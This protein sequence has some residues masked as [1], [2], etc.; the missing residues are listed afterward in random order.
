MGETSKMVGVPTMKGIGSSFKDFGLGAVGGLLFLI[1]YQIFGAIGVLA[2][3]LIAGSMIKGERGQIISTMAGF[4]VIALGV[5]GA[6]GGSSSN[7][8][9][10]SGVM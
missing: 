10:N 7:N 2:A 9:A 5:L 6:S 8:G 3:P 4:L 1:V